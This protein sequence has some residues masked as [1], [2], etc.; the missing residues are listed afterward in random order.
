MTMHEHETPQL[1]DAGRLERPDGRLMEQRAAFE[2]WLNPGGHAGNVSPW[3]EPGRYE[4]DT[5]QLAWLA[6]Q[7]WEDALRQTWQMVDPLKPAGQPGSYWRGQD[8]GITDA[9]TAL[10]ANLKTV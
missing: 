2:A 10:R 6:W 9:L 5:H 1:A 3:V 8:A 7:R 4:K